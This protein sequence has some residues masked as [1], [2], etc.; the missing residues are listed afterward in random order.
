MAAEGEAAGWS[1]AASA[2]GK[3]EEMNVGIQF[4]SSI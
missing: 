4:H 3:Q 2:V 1:R